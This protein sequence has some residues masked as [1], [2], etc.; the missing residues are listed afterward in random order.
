MKITPIHILIYALIVT[1]ALFI[2]ENFYHPVYLIQM[3]QKVL[4]F[5]L[6]PLFIT[7]LLGQTIGRFGRIEKSS[8]IY[9]VSFGLLSVLIIGV[10][11][12]LLRDTIDWKG[13]QTSIEAR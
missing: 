11:Y 9:G 12:L 13:I 10:T 8:I 4:S 7:Y 3:T 6:V 5:L 1:G 2:T